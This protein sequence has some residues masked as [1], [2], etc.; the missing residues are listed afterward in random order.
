MMLNKSG[1]LALATA[2]LW[3]GSAGV[4]PAKAGGLVL[5]TPTGLT[6]GEAFRFV[7]VTD[8]TTTATSTSISTYNTFVNND[9]SNQAGGGLVTYDG[10]TLTWSAIAST[11]STSAIT[12]VGETGAPLYMAANGG[13]LVT[14]SDTSSGLWSGSLI[15]SINQDLNGN[16]NTVGS[17]WTGTLPSGAG[18]PG[19]QLGT[20]DPT[21]GSTLHANAFWVDNFNLSA[22]NDFFLFGVSQVLVA[23][24]VPEPSTLVMAATAL[25]AGCVF[26]WPRRRRSSRRQRTVE[27]T[28]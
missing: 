11:A 9:A 7:F 23:A 21:N 24:S 8:G 5:S 3:I 25:G 6:P 28:E 12:N 19:N 4:G 2:V 26:G 1:L 16:V 13:T 22:S 14:S 18:N 15:N 20:S 10:V 27:Q 17:V